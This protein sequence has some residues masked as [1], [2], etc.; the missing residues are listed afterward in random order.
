M[1][2]DFD[3][4][5]ALLESSGFANLLSAG[6]KGVE[7]ESLRVTADNKLAQTPHPAALGAAL[8]HPYITTDYSEAQLE[9]VTP[10]LEDV[11]NV[12][13][14]QHELHQFTYAHLTDE[15]L[16]SASMPCIVAGEQSVPV[17]RFGPSHVGRFK[18]VY[19]RGLEA[20]YRRIMQIISGVHFNYSVPLE[21][22]PV[23]QE[24]EHDPRP[25]GDFMSDAYLG[26]ARNV[27]RYDWLIT[28]LF[29]CSPA[30][31]KSFMDG[32]PHTFQEYDRY[33]FYEPFATSLRMSNIG[34]KNQASALLN[35]SYD[36]LPG[37][38]NALTHAVRTPY[39]PYQE[40]GVFV[41]GDYR[42]LNANILQIEN[43]FY[44][45][46][47]PKQITAPGER[48]LSAL[49]RRGVAYVE[50]R[51]LDV[52][53]F[54]PVGVSEEQ[55]R[56]LEAFLLFCLLQE[57]APLSPHE[58]AES[59]QNQ[60]LTA[61]EGRR[62]GLKLQRAGRPIRLAEWATTILARVA[63][64]AALLDRGDEAQRYGQAVAGLQATVYDPDLTPSARA[65][66]AMRAGNHSFFAFAGEL[67]HGHRAAF[68]TRPL[69]ARQNQLFT[70]LAEESLRKQAD[71]EAATTGSFAAFLADYAAQLN[72]A[73]V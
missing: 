56:F 31:C 6:R 28:Y 12:M 14:F 5:L 21:L 61:H 54:E 57:S 43:E 15:F 67:A 34:Y 62:P 18:H 52:N 22:W 44:G 26:L 48:P 51:S 45:S 64:V 68:T 17:A 42:Q 9:F 20:R 58:K 66:A 7:K 4:R 10:P 30:L 49:A 69:T 41:D 60:T 1:Y 23:L 53:A 13:A 65:L 50:L 72:P 3:E 32:L 24:I 40:I 16:W 8:T 47:R 29:G 73:R 19:R 33:S 27:M 38:V 70:E 37:Y 46:I 11:R 63:E 55:L 59:A 35:V 39:P 25:Q 2:R 71:L 36:S